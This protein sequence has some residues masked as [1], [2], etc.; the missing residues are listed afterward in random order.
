MEVPSLHSVK[1]LL[2]LGLEKQN[3]KKFGVGR[4]RTAGSS[5]VFAL[6][7]K[8]GSVRYYLIKNNLFSNKMFFIVH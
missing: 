1:T 7:N 2:P 5:S 3:E 6:S 8:H 4:M